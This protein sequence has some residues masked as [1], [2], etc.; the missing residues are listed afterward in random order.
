MQKTSKMLYEALSVACTKHI[1]HNTRFSLRPIVNSNTG[2]VRFTLAIRRPPSMAIAS[3]QDLIWLTVES[4]FVAPSA[5]SHTHSDI[6]STTNQVQLS[7]KRKAAPSIESSTSSPC[8]PKIA[9]KKSVRFCTPSPSSPSNPPPT[10]SNLLNICKHNN[11]CNHLQTVICQSINSHHCIGYLEQGPGAKHL[12][13]IDGK[14]SVRNGGLTKSL[15]DLFQGPKKGLSFGYQSSQYQRTCLANSLATAILQFH[16]T[17]WLSSSLNSKELY[18]D[19]SCCSSLANIDGLREP[20]VDVSVKKPDNMPYEDSSHSLWHFAP[21]LFLFR[22]GVMLLELAFEEPL[23]NMEKPIDRQGKLEDQHAEFFT[24]RRMTRIVSSTMG[25]RYSE[26]VRKCLHC[27]FGRGDDLASPALQ[28]A[29]YREVVCELGQ[30][31]DG[32]RKLHIAD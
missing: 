2:Q 17:P 20:F 4:S 12:V 23:K 31:E 13:Y 10:P 28:E 15:L 21:N 11:L 9:L 22:L 24:A 8:K 30:L 19:S 16:P 7:L 27:D 1:E 26:V 18:F 25:A 14:T 3:S 6:S 5:V 29:F 32:F